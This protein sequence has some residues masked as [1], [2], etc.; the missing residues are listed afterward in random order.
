MYSIDPSHLITDTDIQG[1]YNICKLPK[2]FRFFSPA[3]LFECEHLDDSY[4]MKM[5]YRL[6]F[7]LLEVLSLS[8]LE[9]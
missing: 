1:N 2:F 3:S 4:C 7:L 9:T 6:N 5:S 8:W